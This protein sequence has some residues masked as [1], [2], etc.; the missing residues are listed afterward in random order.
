MYNELFSTVPND[1]RTCFV[2]V[3]SY[4]NKQPVGSVY[5][6]YKER[7]KSFT[8]LM[9]LIELIED[10]VD[11]IEVPS[12]S[13]HRS[14]LGRQKTKCLWDSAKK[15]C[16]EEIGVLASFKVDILYRKRA[17]W[18]GVIC[19]IDESKE[20]CFRSTLE[21]IQLLDSALCASGDQKR[22]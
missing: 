8:G 19:W 7:H 12:E 16:G 1:F 5:S 3:D 21:L 9:G 13:E 2:H 15:G 18:Q 11:D 22:D 6:P 4:D 20:E 14:F 17:S 10:L